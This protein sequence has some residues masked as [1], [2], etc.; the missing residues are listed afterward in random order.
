[1][2]LN[3]TQRQQLKTKI[4]QLVAAGEKSTPRMLHTFRGISIT[5]YVQSG[6]DVPKDPTLKMYQTM[7]INLLSGYNIPIQSNFLQIFIQLN[8]GFNDPGITSAKKIDMLADAIK[9]K[10]I[11][12][13][14]RAFG[15]EPSGSNL[16]STT[17]VYTSIP[18]YSAPQ[19]DFDITVDDIEDVIKNG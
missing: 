8:S 1:M 2:A 3:P 9:I 10:S 11:S 6:T 17:T 14:I 16:S 15:V 4:N 7:Y 13:Q 18:Q 19:I 12:D 5:S